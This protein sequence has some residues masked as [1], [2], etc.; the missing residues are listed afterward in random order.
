[1][2]PPPGAGESPLVSE[3]LQSPPLGLVALLGLPDLHPAVRD[4][5]RTELR[6]PLECCAGPHPNNH[7]HG[8][9]DLAEQASRVVGVRS[10]NRV[11]AG[12][13]T[14]PA[15]SAALAADDTSTVDGKP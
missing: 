9:G 15:A 3:E 2:V 4:H 6:P 1:M 8:A 7:Q 11:A 12:A 14:E 10:R 13:P 5:L